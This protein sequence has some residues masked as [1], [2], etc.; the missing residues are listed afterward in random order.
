MTLN[1]I[2]WDIQR[3]RINRSK[4]DP[5][6]EYFSINLASSNLKVVNCVVFSVKLLLV[7]SNT[8]N[9]GN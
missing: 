7:S 5:S 4:S 6:I 3:E 2:Q 1:I 8:H 9:G